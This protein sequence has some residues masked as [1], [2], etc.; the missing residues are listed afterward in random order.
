MSRRGGLAL[1]RARCRDEFCDLCTA[2]AEEAKAARDDDPGFRADYM[3]NVFE[4][5]MEAS[6]P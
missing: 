1:H 3:D 6:W 5:A 4:H 2:A